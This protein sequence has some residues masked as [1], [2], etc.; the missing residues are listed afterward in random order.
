MRV[1]SRFARASDIMLMAIVPLASVDR[2]PP[3]PPVRALTDPK[4]CR[5]GGAKGFRAEGA[6]SADIKRSP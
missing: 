6:A 4:N 5:T 2:L 1:T 3:L